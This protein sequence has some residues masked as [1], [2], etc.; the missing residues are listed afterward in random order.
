MS[1][2]RSEVAG[3]SLVLPVAIANRFRPLAA[4]D[5]GVAAEFGEFRLML[6]PP[7][8]RLRQRTARGVGKLLGRRGG[9][10]RRPCPGGN[11]IAG[12]RRV[13][14]G[15][16]TGR[17]DRIIRLLH[18]KSSPLSGPVSG[19]DG[20]QA[21]ARSA[22]ALA[23]RRLAATALRHVIEKKAS[24]EDALARSGARGAFD[25][26][27][28]DRQFARSITVITLKR[29]GGLRAAL[30]ARLK[31][32][33]DATPPEIAATLLVGA[34]Q[35]LFMAV[36]SHAAVD[37]AVEL[38]SVGSPTRRTSGARQRRVAAGRRRPLANPVLP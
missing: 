32:P 21:A 3:D 30:N 12:R 25:L 18:M 36:P 29:L 17:H 7:G 31:K 34:A 24:L 4:A 1:A 2:Y 27:T 28:R 23:A 5:L 13:A 35:I 9:R 11:C 37:V 22:R 26:D 14:W 19:G 20:E 15:W 33:V 16:L 38:T 10:W 6:R 8:F